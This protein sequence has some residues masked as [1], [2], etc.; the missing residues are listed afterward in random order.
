MNW[1]KFDLD[2]EIIFIPKKPLRHTVSW[3]VIYQVGAVY[4][5]DNNGSNPSGGNRKQDAT[6]IINGNTYRVTLLRGANND[7]TAKGHG[8]DKPWTDASEWNRLMYSVHSGVHTNSSNPSY[9]SVPYNVWDSY[10]DDDLLVH[11]DFGNG[12]YSWTQETSG[13]DS[14]SRIFRGDYGVTS[15]GRYKSTNST[16]SYGWRPALR[17]V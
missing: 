4:G 17:L 14:A 6:V 7:P 13:D 3:E 5:T 2:G 16:I 1:L 8:Y 15:V 11:C 12:I 9:A 10:S